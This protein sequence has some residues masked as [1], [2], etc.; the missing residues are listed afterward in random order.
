MLKDLTILNGEM[1]LKFNSLNTIYT[2]TLNDFEESLEFDYVIDSENN[3]SIIGNDIKEGEN[4]VVLTVYNDNEMMSYYL[5]VYKEPSINVNTNLNNESAL[6]VSK[7]NIS[8]YAVPIISSVCFLTII[9]FFSL[10]FK[11]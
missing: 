4:E 8:E 1:D 9:I 10:L 2:I 5:S 3:L 11:K 6:E 7:N